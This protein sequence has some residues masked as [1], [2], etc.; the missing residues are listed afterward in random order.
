MGLSEKKQHN[1]AFAMLCLTAVVWGVGFVLNKLLLENGFEQIPLTLNA[2]RFTLG[3][4]VLWVVFGRKIHL[5]KQLLLFGGLCGL[6]LSGGFGLQIL[7]LKYTT[8]SANGFYT[9]L[10]TIYVPFVAWAVNKRRPS[11]I[12]LL[13]VLS[14]LIG[15]VV[16]N[17]PNPG[18]T[19][20][21]E[22]DLLGISLSLAG[23]LF[24]GLQI[25]FADKAMNEIKLDAL[26]MTVIQL[27]VCAVVFVLTSAIFE[28]GNFA[29][30]QMNFGT[31]AWQMAIVSLLGTAFAYFSQ[32]NA[33]A[34]LSPTETSVIIACESPIGAIFSVALGTEA[35]TWQV[36]V[37]GIFVVGAI[38]IMEVLP[39]LL[40]NKKQ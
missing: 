21:G 7:G 39:N 20:M 30:V 5:T 14:A 15:L 36:A 9:A 22:N 40:K 26:G 17:I 37:G 3:A 12:M 8:P 11:K 13:G 38:L 16:L 35:F 24:F 10:Y 29:S 4:L 25:V 34:Y 32:T 31:C 19:A 18:E 1:M 27:T 6:F 28:S 23:S 33:Q 2:V